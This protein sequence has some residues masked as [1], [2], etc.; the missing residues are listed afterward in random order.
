MKNIP[1]INVSPPE[2]ETVPSPKQKSTKW[3]T[4][5]GFAL[6][7][8]LVGLILLLIKLS[9]SVCADLWEA[10]K[11]ITIPQAIIIAAILVSLAITKTSPKKGR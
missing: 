7:A 9:N 8:V 11:Q 5:V 6:I 4:A 10:S 3:N 2:F 1:D